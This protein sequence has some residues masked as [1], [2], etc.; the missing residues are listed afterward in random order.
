[1]LGKADSDPLRD[2]ANHILT[3]LIAA[4]DPINQLPPESDSEGDRAT[5]MVG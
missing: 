2:K 1:V 3:V 5:Y 4:T